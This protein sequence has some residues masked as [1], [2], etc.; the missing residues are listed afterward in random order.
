[1]RTPPAIRSALWVW[2]IAALLAGRLQ[3]LP[4][5][6]PSAVAGLLGDRKSV[7]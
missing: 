1:M 6:P 7:V 2:L 3:L 4:R 5:V